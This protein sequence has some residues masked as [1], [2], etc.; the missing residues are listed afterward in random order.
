MPKVTAETYIRERVR[1]D[2]A[3]HWMWTGT[4][5]MNGYPRCTAGQHASGWAHRMSHETFTGPIPPGHTIDHLCRVRA[6]VNPA[7]L[8]AVTQ[9]ENNLRAP[10]QLTPVNLA[11]TRC[12]QGHPYDVANTYVHKTGKRDCRTC[13]AAA[14]ARYRRRLAVA[15]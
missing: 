2:A 10:T 12:P 9:R 3:G 11:K 5:H 13:R 14:C 6:C 15:S 4:I 7:H 1:I 8:E